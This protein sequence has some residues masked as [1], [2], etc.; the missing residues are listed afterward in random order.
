MEWVAVAADY[1]LLELVGCRI[2]VTVSAVSVI[3]ICIACG[4]RGLF[5]HLLGFLSP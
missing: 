5:L 3:L 2:A 4:L 1:A